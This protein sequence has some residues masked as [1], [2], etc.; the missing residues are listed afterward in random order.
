MTPSLSD[1]IAIYFRRWWHCLWHL[2]RMETGYWHGRTVYVG[3]ECGHL[4]FVSGDSGE[5]IMAHFDTLRENRKSAAA[6]RA[7]TP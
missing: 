7:R 3:C 5:L 1:W 6:G 4:W 2:H